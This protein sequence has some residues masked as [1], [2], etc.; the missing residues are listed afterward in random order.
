[1]KKT[2]TVVALCM[3]IVFAHSVAQE[4]HDHDEKPPV[5]LKVLPKHTSGEEIHRIMRGYSRSLG[6]RCGFCHAQGPAGPDGKPTLDFASDEKPEKDIARK[7]I[8]MT[9]AINDKYLGKIKADHALEQITC[10]TCHMGNIKPLISADSL[11]KAG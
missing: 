4:H 5:N 2:A 8:K 9:D 7:M 6:V 10:A 1:M 11:K 3:I